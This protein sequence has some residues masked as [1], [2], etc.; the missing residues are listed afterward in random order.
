[1][2]QDSAAG[3]CIA[4]ARIRYHD[5]QPYDAVVCMYHDQGLIPLKLKQATAE[6]ADRARA[7]ALAP[8][9]TVSTYSAQVKRVREK[10][11]PI[12]EETEF[13]DGSHLVKLLVPYPA[14]DR[15]L[16]EYVFPAGLAVR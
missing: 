8:D 12:E 9:P 10:V 5:D 16:S 6:Y 4:A 15:L 11:G 14:A 7:A 3:G 2:S 1:M 13:V